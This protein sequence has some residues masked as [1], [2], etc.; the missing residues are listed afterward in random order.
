MEPDTNGASEISILYVEDDLTTRDLICTIIRLKFPGLHLLSAANGQSG[1]ELYREH[2]PDIVLTDISM[3]VMDGIR[4]ASEIRA[5]NRDANIIL[6]TAH[7]DTRYLLNAIKMGINR[8]VLKPIDNVKLF[9]AIEDSVSRITLERQVRKQSEYICKLSRA[10]EQSPCMVIITDAKGV[11][12][13]VNP[14]FTGITGYLPEEV[15]AQKPG[16]PTSNETASDYEKLWST[17]SAGNEWQGE[18]QSRKKNGEL[19]WES[20]SI[21]PLCDA[22]GTITNYVAVKEDITERKRAEAQIRIL[23]ADLEKR[24][25]ER[26]AELEESN[27]ELEAF[28]HAISHELRAPIAR[29]EGYREVIFECFMSGDYGDLQF[30]VERLG[31]SAQQLKLVVD[32]LLMMNRLSKTEITSELIN[33]SELSRQ[34]MAELIEVHG[35][36]TM[37]FQVA[38]DVFA[39]GDRKLLNICMHNLLGNAYKYTS[40]TPVALIEFGAEIRAGQKVYFVRDNGAGFDMKYVSKLFQPF[41]RLHN[42]KEFKGTGIGLA[43]VHRIIEKHE[44]KIWAES[45]VDEGTTIYFTLGE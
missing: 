38:P 22:D 26:T 15:V 33:L 28:C 30:Y 39:R 16:I 13:Y 23:N 44:G 12:E 24:V 19:Y 3:P 14:K 25:L 9:E 6:I 20:A 18:F 36:R 34:V 1:L 41:S 37:Q 42:E 40:K 10:V 2:R 43:T 21:S 32:G 8:Y 5:L 31:C 45:K 35:E 7:S 27:K 29:L 17:I 4:L 11:V